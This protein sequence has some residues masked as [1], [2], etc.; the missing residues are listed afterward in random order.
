MLKEKK[1]GIYSEE[2]SQSKILDK[3]HHI[4]KIPK[5]G[6]GDYKQWLEQ[7]DFLQFLLDT[8][9]GDIPL[10]VSYK[11]TYI[12]SVFLQQNRLRGNYIDDLMKWDCRPD[13]SWG[14]SFS[15][16]KKGDIQNIS[17][18]PPFNFSRSRLLKN[19]V[20]ITFLRSFEGR[21]GQKSYIEVLQLLTHLNGL[22]FIEE[23]SAYCRLN[24]DG[25]I[26]EIIKIHHAPGEILVT[27][28][29]NV[30]DYHLFLSKS[31]LLRLFDRTLC[32]D[33][34]S[35]SEKSRNESNFSDKKNNIYAH[36]VISFDK[37]N[38]PTAGALRGFQIVHNSQPRKKMLKII[39]GERSKPQKYE[40]F[41][42]Y[43]WKHDKIVSCSCDPK[44][45]SNYYEKSDKPSKMSPAFFRPDVL[46]KYKQNPE[47][48]TLDQRS[49]SCR[50]SWRLKTYDINK[51]GQVHTYLVY[52]GYLPHSEQLHWKSCNEKPK[53]EISTR[54][55]TTDFMGRW[56]LSY[57][58]LSE[59]KKALKELEQTK[60]ELWSCANEKL[61][62]QLNYPITDS[63]KEWIDEIHTLD[64][65]VVEGLKKA[66]LKKIA[67]SLNCYENKLNSITLL[68]KI[69]ETKGIDSHEINEIISPLEEIHFL[70][71]K[72]AG[73]S[74]GKEADN[75]R[76]D[77][78]A[79]HGDLRKHFR[80]LVEITDK[81][82]KELKHIQL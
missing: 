16:N 8:C 64:K 79:K 10:Y 68:K 80:A 70:R 6:T 25:D 29:Q 20:P 39:N 73:H 55:F 15:N 76:K 24:E 18:T 66:Y 5:H 9:Y 46:L 71:T 69:L 31:V 65:L 72:F 23:K 62:Q 59:L 17:L 37:E 61:Y 27:I 44:K 78:I 32:N 28:K 30:L 53:A 1:T 40:K 56:D 47:K 81:S 34:V 77:L 49:I 58:P 21:I 63:L 38:L 50:G 54:A 33:W 3:L 52:L 43:D 45:L 57:E 36:Q 42:A 41:I 26:E 14:Y 4:S 12:Y 48:Y 35:F 82:I 2:M 7:K 67:K 51:A 13:S 60:A 75:I 11:G 22:H 19:A 74:S